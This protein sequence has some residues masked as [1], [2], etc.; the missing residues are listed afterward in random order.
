M[1]RIG[2]ADE[3]QENTEEVKKVL[4][5]TTGEIVKGEWTKV[6]RRK[7]YGMKD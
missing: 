2:N 3:R 7:E 5:G 4:V 6:R 1:K